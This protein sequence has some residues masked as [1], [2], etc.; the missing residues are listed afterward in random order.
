[1]MEALNA[2]IVGTSRVLQNMAGRFSLPGLAEI[3]PRGIPKTAIVISCILSGALLF[4]SNSFG[5]LASIAVVT[6][7]VPKTSPSAR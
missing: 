5:L 2:S 6:A 1:M 4:F 3:T 7:L